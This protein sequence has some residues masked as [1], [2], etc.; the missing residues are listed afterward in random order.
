VMVIKGGQVVVD[1]RQRLTERG[2]FTCTG[3]TSG[4]KQQED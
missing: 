1:R 2:E 3:L 4:A